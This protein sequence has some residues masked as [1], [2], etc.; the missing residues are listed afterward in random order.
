MSP[1]T[2]ALMSSQR[3]VPASL[4][5]QYLRSYSSQIIK[6]LSADTRSRESIPHEATALQVVF[7]N[8]KAFT[9]ECPNEMG[10]LFKKHARVMGVYHSL[11]TRYFAE[12]PSK[13]WE[14]APP[15]P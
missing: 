6:R 15:K 14:K 1:H 13:H 7:E 8:P 12:G 4:F 10:V 3:Q 11:A 5:W 2:A 9:K